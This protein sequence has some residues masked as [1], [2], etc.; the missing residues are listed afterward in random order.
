MN[1]H[2]LKVILST[3]S[4]TMATCAG[5]YM[6]S[7]SRVLRSEYGRDDSATNQQQHRLTVSNEAIDEKEIMTKYVF[8]HT[9]T[10]QDFPRAGVLFQDIFPI[11]RNPVA[12]DALVRLLHSQ[13][14]RMCEKTNGR[15]DVIVALDARGFLLGPILALMSNCAFTPVRKAGKL[16]G[17][18]YVVQYEKEYGSDALS[19]QKDSV[20]EGGFFLLLPFSCLNAR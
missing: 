12:V 18:C 5:I 3:V 6:L 4:I 8:D 7:K 1:H 20:R 14:V 13:I 10:Y 16:P 19:M 11:F 17:E 15:P 2:D 9:K